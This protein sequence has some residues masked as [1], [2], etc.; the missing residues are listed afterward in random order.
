MKVA[1]QVKTLEVKKDNLEKIITNSTEQEVIKIITGINTGEKYWKQVNRRMQ[2]P[3]PNME[4]YRPATY[5]MHTFDQY[6]E[7]KIYKPFA[8]FL[9]KAVVKF[10]HLT[11]YVENGE[12]GFSPVF[13]VCYLNS[14]RGNPYLIKFKEN[15][16]DKDI[17]RKM[18]RILYSKKNKKKH[19]EF[20]LE[21]IRP[22]SSYEY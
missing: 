11:L 18:V 7:C 9:M 12:F 22:L 8:D 5:S 10:P 2:D 6:R 4:P 16:L 19:T 13:G 21:E 15:H 14:E 17:Y 20:G 3:R 1:T